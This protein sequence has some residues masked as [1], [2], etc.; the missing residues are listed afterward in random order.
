MRYGSLKWVASY[1]QTHQRQN[2]SVSFFHVYFKGRY[3]VDYVLNQQWQAPVVE[4]KSIFKNR[5]GDLKVVG[6]H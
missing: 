1:Q 3:M 5:A 4:D 2:S 6:K